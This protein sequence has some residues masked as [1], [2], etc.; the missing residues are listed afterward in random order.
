[1]CRMKIYEVVEGACRNR[2]TATL[3]FTRDSA[4]QLSKNNQLFKIPF[5]IDRSN[6]LCSS[7]KVDKCAPYFASSRSTRALIDA[8][9]PLRNSL[10][11]CLR[12][13]CKIRVLG[14]NIDFTNDTKEERRINMVE[15]IS[16]VMNN[17]SSYV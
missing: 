6:S 4:E 9:S 16:Y 11:L 15:N 7:N 12:T 14:L 17:L 5:D 8:I 10:S 2:I 13:R 3:T 1:M